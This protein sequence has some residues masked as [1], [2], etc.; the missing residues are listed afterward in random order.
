MGEAPRPPRH[1]NASLPVWLNDLILKA[2]AKKPEER[3][4]TMNEMVEALELGLRGAVQ[5]VKGHA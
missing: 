5:T 4:A 3:F 2:L 1:L